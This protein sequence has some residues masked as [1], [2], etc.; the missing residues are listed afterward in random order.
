MK[1]YRLIVPDIESSIEG[2]DWKAIKAVF[3]ELPPEDIAEILNTLDRKRLPFLFRLVPSE[4]SVSVFAALDSPLQEYILTHLGDPEVSSL[5]H[6]MDPDD[7]TSLLEDLPGELVQRVVNL[8]DD[9]HRKEVLTLLGYPE[10]SVGR[11]MTPDYVAV[12]PFWSMAKAFDH[13]RKYGKDAE[14]IDMVYVV[15]ENWKLLDDI[16][17]RRFI[18]AEQRSTMVRDIMDFHFVA[19]A[20]DE[21]QE[22]AYLLIKKYDL[23]ALP[24][25]DQQGVLLGIVTVDDI[26]DV[27]EEEVDEDFQKTSAIVPLEQPY[28]VVSPVLLFRRR[29]GWLLIL[30][31]TDF[32]SSS[33]IAHYENAIKAVIA[34]AFFIPVLIDSG[35]NIAA[36]A[37]TLV[38]RA[39][40]TG[41]L[42]VARWLE[43]IRK[44]LVVGL[45]IGLTLGVV[46]YLRGF[47]W[48]GGPTIGMVVGI[49]M[50]GIT[51]WSNLLGAFLPIILT[52]LRLDPAIVSN[53]LLT[54]VVDSTGLLIYFSVARMVFRF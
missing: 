2:E 53:P 41:E 17:I 26:I 38:I 27:A 37:S 21:D 14:T 1:I 42:T 45:L 22:Q 13:I 28:R 15:D 30:L 52:K 34:L 47:I 50:I 32:L 49:S 20:A 43:V 31:L 18:L 29:I 12:R 9:E 36:Q 51:I 10:K 19:I 54:T 46:L 24:V 35:G 11:L 6:N 39:L 48:R 16:P 40:A 3:Q 5:I 23:P 25:V 33:I 8:L 4:K 44:E 7:R